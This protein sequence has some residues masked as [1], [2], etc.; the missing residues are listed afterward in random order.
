M[1]RTVTV[2]IF[3]ELVNNPPYFQQKLGPKLNAELIN[4]WN[5]S[6]HYSKPCC[7]IKHNPTVLAATPLL[8]LFL[9]VCVLGV[10]LHWNGAEE[11]RRN[12]VQCVHLSQGEGGWEKHSFLNM[13]NI[14]VTQNVVERDLTSFSYTSDLERYD[15]QTAVSTCALRL[16]SVSPSN[17]KLGAKHAAFASHYLRSESIE[18]RTNHQSCQNNYTCYSPRT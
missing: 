6:N 9:S 5:I 18:L 3:G 8:S 11:A 10:Y 4:L 17:Q 13:R 2:Q 15:I 12:Q 16:V 14:C 7:L 1:A